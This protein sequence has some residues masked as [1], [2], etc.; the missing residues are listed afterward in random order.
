M[1]IICN[2]III[3][4][5]V[6]GAGKTTVGKKLAGELGWAF[7]DADDFHSQANIKKMA[8]G[9]PLTDADRAAWLDELAR[10]IS[11]LDQ[12]GQSAVLACSALKKAYRSKLADA[13]TDVKFVYL[14]GNY[15]LISRR[16]K[17]RHEHF[18]KVKLL[19]SQFKTLEEPK[20]AL[21]VEAA[22]SPATTVRQIR[23]SLD[24]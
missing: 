9:I 8:S 6:S 15:D 10:L 13:A 19:A 22:Q 24:L 2:V 3:V 1:V 17:A 14:K 23:E 4:T 16:M 11:R 20:N 12:K 21:S 7:Y 18:M 5:G